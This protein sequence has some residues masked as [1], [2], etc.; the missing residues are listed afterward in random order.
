[1]KNPNVPLQILHVDNTYH[2]STMEIF[3]G[4]DPMYEPTDSDFNIP[5]NCNAFEKSAP[6]Q[7]HDMFEIFGDVMKSS[8][9]GK[10]KNNY[11]KKKQGFSW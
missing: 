9:Y 11:L 4:F 2:I 5:P 8:Q 3:Y 6:N 7:Y 10:T 1:M